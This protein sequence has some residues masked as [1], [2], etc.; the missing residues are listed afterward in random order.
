MEWN[1]FQI[2]FR[3]GFMIYEL[4]LGMSKDLLFSCK[5][6]RLNYG[7]SQKLQAI[8]LKVNQ[9]FPHTFKKQNSNFKIFL[10]QLLLSASVLKLSLLI[11]RRVNLV[12]KATLRQDCPTS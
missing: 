1:V 3:T 9:F 5:F 6:Q 10:T 12:V 2:V 4:N 7:K 11:D 8:I